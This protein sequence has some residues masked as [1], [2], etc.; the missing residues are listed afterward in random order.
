[1]SKL[2]RFAA[3]IPAAGSGTRL[4][5]G[6]PKALVELNGRTLLDRAIDNLSPLVDEVVVALP[7]GHSL[8][9][10]VKQIEGG[11][12]RQDTVFR[13]LQATEAEF[14]LIHDAARPF[15]SAKVIERIK[16]RVVQSGAVTAA[17]PATDTLVHASGGFWGYLVDRSKTWAV[18]TPQAFRRNTILDAHLKALQE[19]FDA[20]DDA[21]LASRYASNVEL[22]LGDSR[23]FKVT[24]PADFELATAFAQIWDQ[25]RSSAQ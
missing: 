17:L 21:G 12:T 2:P 16:G 5:F 7:A 6:V 11:A 19:G 23:L 18:Q 1:M 14:V 10:G 3:L 24:T 4:G 25:K 8:D 13:L 20:T 15:L 9:Q 22:V